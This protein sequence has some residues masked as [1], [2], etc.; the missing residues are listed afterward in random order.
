MKGCQL[1]YR[2]N[3]VYIV[4]LIETSSGICFVCDPMIKISLSEPPEKLGE[5]L[6]MVLNSYK[7]GE[8]LQSESKNITKKILKFL[9]AKS[10]KELEK[11]TKYVGIHCDFQ[12]VFFNLTTLGYGGGFE[13]TGEYLQCNLDPVEIGITILKALRVN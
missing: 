9:E 5:I 11:N 1:Y 2:N 12:Q 6:L 3:N 10:W 4:S 8:L 13:Q 7:K